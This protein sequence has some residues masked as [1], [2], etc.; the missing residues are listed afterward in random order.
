M[1]DNIKLL[2]VKTAAVGVLLLALLYYR[3]RTKSLSEAL[4]EAKNN[5]KMYQNIHNK[6][7]KVRREN[8]VRKEKAESHVRDVQEGKSERDFFE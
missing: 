4:T 6:M 5:N 3:S 8:N 2:A 1:L 7:N